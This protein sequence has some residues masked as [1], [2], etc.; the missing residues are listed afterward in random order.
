MCQDTALVAVNAV[1][2][3]PQIDTEI[4]DRAIVPFSRRL[5]AQAQGR[6]LNYFLV[7]ESAAEHIRV[8][9]AEVLPYEAVSRCHRAPCPDAPAIEARFDIPSTRQPNRT[10]PGITAP[11]Q[12]TLQAVIRL[13]V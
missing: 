10:I 9:G 12:T 5:A 3:S 13:T 6:C 2:V 1:V 8:V 11:I 7:V 4:V